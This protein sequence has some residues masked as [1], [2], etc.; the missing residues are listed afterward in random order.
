MFCT[1]IIQWDSER[2]KIL[3]HAGFKTQSWLKCFAIFFY[4]SQKLRNLFENSKNDLSP[5]TN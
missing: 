4:F 2:D 1:Y 3:G 5:C